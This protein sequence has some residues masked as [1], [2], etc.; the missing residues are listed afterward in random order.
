MAATAQAQLSVATGSGAG[1]G[2]TATDR[3]PEWRYRLKPGET[4]EAAAADL[5]A[6]GYDSQQLVQYNRL[7]DPDLLTDGDAIAI[8]MKWLKRQP[9]PAVITAA[10][11]QGHVRRNGTGRTEPAR[12]DLRLRVGDQIV[13][14][15]GE[16][17]V[18]LGNGSVI[19]VHPNS[20]LIFDRLT[21]Y[22][23]T[24]MV[25]TRL[26]LERGKASNAVAPLVED[27]S[28]YE[29]E[30]PSAVAAVRGTRFSLESERDLTR[31]RVTEGNVAFGQRDSMRQIRE[32][33][34]AE[35]G[36]RSRGEL[37]LRRLPAA[38][39]T[40][41]LPARLTLFPVELNWD[42]SGAPEHQLNIFD[43]DTGENV[44][45][46][47]IDKPPAALEQLDNGRYRIQLAALTSNGLEGMPSSQTVDVDL[48]ARAAELIAPDSDVRVDTDRPEFQWQYRGENEV[49]RLEMAET[50]Q[51]EA[52]LA[53]TDW[54][55]KTSAL[56]SQAL[57]PGQYYWRVVTKTGGDSIARTEPRKII[58][59]GTLPPARIIN[60]NYVD[61]QV[62]IVWEKVDTAG[63]YQLQLAEDPAFDNIIKE[64]SVADTT[65]ALRLIPG[66]RYFVRIKAL[67]EGPLASRWGPARELFIE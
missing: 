9:E 40:S 55:A 31:L 14:Q 3:I 24:G 47:K 20:K 50:K 5:L 10:S 63:D 56:P 33:Y 4:L 64:A 42:D 12:K 34:S 22:G 17:T 66:R 62:R 57:A 37:Q 21:Q 28:R 48:Q 45:S 53:N 29:I 25:D 65:A 51:F 58:I 32:G 7:D 44:I 1:K 49:S 6:S 59:N 35:I 61:K 11:G 13:T 8:P 16:A 54:N 43:A 36:S 30:T 27:G 23:K 15:A 26:R 67:S 39:D 52:L 18:T 38:P 60:V 46:R 41:E 19:R 2:A